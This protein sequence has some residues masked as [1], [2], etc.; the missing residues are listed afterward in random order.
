MPDCGT[1]GT[2]TPAGIHRGGTGLDIMQLW[3]EKPHREGNPVSD[4]HKPSLISMV[5]L[6]TGHW[7]K[8]KSLTRPAV[9][10]LQCSQ[11]VKLKVTLK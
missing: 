10:V 11:W 6:A 1:A 7:E 8:F 3:R 9:L 4:C 5:L 2:C